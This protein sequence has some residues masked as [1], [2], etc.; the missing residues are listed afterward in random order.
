M[1]T[2]S[3]VGVILI[4]ENEPG[5]AYELKL[6][7]EFTARLINAVNL[8]KP[9]SKPIKIISHYDGDGLSA[10]A[11][12]CATL[13]RLEKPFHITLQHNLDPD[14]KIFSDLK[15]TKDIVKIFCD[16]GSGSVSEIE[17]LPGWSIILDHHSPKVD[18]EKNNIVHINTHLFGINGTYELS[19]ATLAFIFS[20]QVSDTNWDLL[21]IALAGA[22]ADK[23]H[24]NG[25]NG[26]NLQL[27]RTGLKKDILHEHKALKL[28]EGSIKQSLLRSTDPYIIGLSN[29]E[30]GVNDLLS[31]L[32]LDPDLKIDQLE[33]SKLQK[34]T[35]YIILKLLDQGVPPED[36]Q[37]FITTR[38]YS[39]K[40]NLEL[41]ELSHII[42]A[43][44]RMTRMGI[45]VAAALGDPEALELAIELRK[46]HKQNILDGLKKLEIEPPK[47]LENIQYFYEE[48]ADFAGT[49]AGIGM[50]YFFEQTKPVIALTK[51]KDKLKISGRGTTRLV[52]KG[53][54][55]AEILFK[56]SA[57]LNGTGGGH[58]IAAGAT[59]PVAVEVEFLKRVDEM[60]GEQLK[61]SL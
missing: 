3:K 45:G 12:I 53:L 10:G 31:K 58:Q 40:S 7:N 28:P 23:Q 6:T 17:E 24:K 14:S 59:I 52:N 9:S 46:E 20:I 27:I 26:M 18:S 54:N 2:I 38:Y 34:L 29:N 15:K 57:E 43:S 5:T 37:E 42:N 35:S 4:K 48:T 56:V 36:A 11:V 25:F 19:A 30:S 47:M 61:G 44:G 39:T 32:K 55:L 22:M 21:P 8:V 1:K 41:E 60:V 49:F 33:K 50:M 51:D 13:I 16:L